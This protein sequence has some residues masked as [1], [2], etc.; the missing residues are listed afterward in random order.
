VAALS[1]AA[2]ALPDTRDLTELSLEEL[3]KI[4][5]TS[6]SK[7][8]ESLAD[9][10]AA[11]AVI[12]NEAIRRYGAT[13]I[14]DALRL[15]P[16]IFVAQG[17][18]NI[19]GVSSRGFSSGNSAKLLVLSDTR[20]IYTPLFSGVFWD[21]QDILLEDVDRIEVIRGPGASLWGSNAVNGVINITSKSAKE[22]QGAY[23]EGGGGTKERGFGAARYGGT[24]ADGIYFRVF[25]K[26]FDRAGE[27]NPD[28]PSGDNWKLGHLG[29]RA[30]WDLAA[31]DT[32]TFQGDAY[33]GDIGQ[34]SPSLVVGT[35]PGP[36]GKLVADV[37]GGNVLARWTHTFAKGSNLQVRAYYDATHRD[38]PSFLDNLDT[39]D[40]DLQ[41]R[42]Q[43][44][45]GQEFLWGLNYRSM[46][47]RLHSKQ[48]PDLLKPPNS[49]DN[50]L[51][52]FVQDQIAV[53]DSLKLT[54]GTKLEHNDFSGFEIQPT[55]RFA[56]SPLPEQTLWGAV[57][58]A[59]RIPTR[60]ERDI[61]VDVTDPSKS[62]LLHYFGD[63]GYG[64]EKLLAYELGYRWQ[65]EKRLFLDLAAYLNVYRGL[66]SLEFAP[67][68]VDPAT[69]QTIIPIV[70]K[71]LTDGL[72]RGGEASLTLTPVR[73]WRLV[74]NYSYLLLTLEPKGQ[75][76]NG[77]YV[78]AGSTPRNLFSLQSF[79]DLPDHFQLDAL[80]RYSTAVLSASQI[81][82]DQEIPNF[83]ELDVRVAWQGLQHLDISLVGRNL[84][85]AH[86]RELPGGLE[87]QR[88][89]YAKI[90]G[91]F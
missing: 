55:A 2:A 35:R 76:L 89:V 73:S 28:G 53:V 79:V 49:Q 51:S 38:D 91:R 10:A 41:H 27:F 75:D 64:S 72:A 29:F 24:L 30:D 85:H 48:I 12:S 33:A 61:D 23:F 65:I 16:G 87:M 15:A 45:L 66:L 14:P 17:T 84:L 3:T 82:K 71:N 70:N 32:L 34:I 22:T 68:Y 44:P 21:V 54:L 20:S 39:F 52:G 83:A 50:V 5:V 37:A 18:S 69:G 77:G 86:H 11:V 67:S 8:E 43:L 57:S 6:V 56:W 26:G 80:F 62:P 31:T 19:W 1:I 63:R 88:A 42:F 4:E 40:L 59:V 25:A 90:A 81:V 74:A 78:L 60:F 58:R 46:Y 36:T 9:A 47:D 13:T 7:T